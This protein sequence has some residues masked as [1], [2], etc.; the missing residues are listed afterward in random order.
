MKI[1]PMKNKNPQAIQ[2]LS[3]N[4]L[5]ASRIF[6]AVLSGALLFLSFPKFGLGVVAWF[7]FV[8]LF[9]ALKDVESVWRSLLLGWIAGM[10]SCVGILY[11]ITHV[12]VNFGNL[13]LYLGIFLMLLLAFYLSFYTALFAAGIVLLRKGVPLYLSAPVLWM[14]LE[15]VKSKAFTGFPWENLGYSQFNNL[16]LIQIADVIGVFGL[17]FLI[18]LLNTTFYS[19]MTGKFKRS[20]TLAA[21]VFLLWAGIYFYGVQRIAQINELLKDAQGMEVSL[22]QGNI[23][24]SIKWNRNYQQETIN[25]YEELSLSRPPEAGGLIVWPETAVPFHF[26]DDSD[27]QR[28]VKDIPRKTQNWFV[29]GS[30]SYQDRRGDTDFYNS[31]FLLSPLGDIQG[32]YDKVHLVPYGEYVPMRTVFPFVNK[33]AEGIG[34]FGEGKGFFPLKMGTRKIGVMICYEGIL[35]EAARMYKNAGAELLVNITNDAWFGSTSAPYQHL[36]MTI[37]RAVETRLYLVRAANTGIS[38][39]VH[40]TGKILTKTGIFHKDMIRGEIKYIQLPTVYAKFGDWPVG[41]GFLCLAIFFL[42]RFIRRGR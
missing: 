37:F 11:W 9:I 28:H 31:A 30:T 12:V 26:Q 5:S 42:W 13:P 20:F 15:Y 8:P 19:F 3:D 27:L 32:K 2:E 40:P 17:S 24:Q 14:C 29:F 39:I 36:S 38:A 18:V 33:L 16:F 34:D 41:A 1:F 7:A 21:I 6:F 4:K 10:A 35:S 25:I 22:V 23:N